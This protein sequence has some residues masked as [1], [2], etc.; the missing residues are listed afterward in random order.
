M[1]GYIS[2]VE[3]MGLVDGPGLRYVVFMQ[4]CKLRCLYCHNPET[5]QMGKGQMITTDELLNKILRYKNYYIKGGVT[6]SGGE[7]LIQKDFL[8]DILKK[9]KASNLH[10]ALD[11]A[12]VGAGD[13]E[14]ILKYVDLVILDVKATEGKSYQQITSSN[15]DEFTKFLTAAKKLNKD[16]WI[17]SVIVPG[18]NDNKEY[19]LSLKEYISKIPNVL[20]V[21]LLPYHLYGIDKYKELNLKYPLDKVPPM[22]LDKLKELENIYEKI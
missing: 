10:T 17:R 3:P 16:F 22:D 6:F 19:I 13:Y 12:G 2:S 1:Q 7:P 18:L 14:E 20:K 5:R 8:I 9:C 11:T 15:M 4:G 21:E